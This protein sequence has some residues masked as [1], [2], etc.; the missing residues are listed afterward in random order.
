M[1]LKPGAG[2]ARECVCA[3]S[4]HVAPRGKPARPA[5]RG[6]CPPAENRRTPARVA[7]IRDRR[8]TRPTR[9]Q[10]P[11]PPPVSR[12][13]GEGLGSDRI[14]CYLSA[15]RSC[16]ATRVVSS[17]FSRIHFEIMVS[18]RLRYSATVL[19]RCPA[20]LATKANNRLARA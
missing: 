20:S 14:V 18:S 2:R 8:A 16:V 17:V 5:V 3:S 6:G 12:G 15:T 9:W 4:H 13:Y 7:G 1:S 10:C 19:F 11:S